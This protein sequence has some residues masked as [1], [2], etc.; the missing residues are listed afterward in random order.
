[1][2]INSEKSTETK[3]KYSKK[4]KLKKKKQIKLYLKK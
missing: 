3:A 4:H 1:M 2:S